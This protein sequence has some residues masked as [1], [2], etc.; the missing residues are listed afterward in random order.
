MLGLAPISGPPIRFMNTSLVS[1]AKVASS[2]P[3]WNGSV[4]RMPPR[5]SGVRRAPMPW[6]SQVRPSSPPSAWQ[7]AQAIIDFVMP[8]KSACPALAGDAAPRLSGPPDA[9]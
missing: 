1:A 5:R 2:P 4:P 9:K 6:K 8:W 7:E 3:Q